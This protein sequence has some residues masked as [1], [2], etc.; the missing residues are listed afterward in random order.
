MSRVD[1][2]KRSLRTCEKWYPWWIAAAAGDGW[3]G[4]YGYRVVFAEEAQGT[5]GLDEAK[6]FGME[7]FG[8]E[9]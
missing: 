2:S 8:G 5:L 6:H 1:E 9:D 4:R 7:L 3:G